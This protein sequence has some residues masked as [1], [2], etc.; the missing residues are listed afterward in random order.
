MSNPQTTA[1]KPSPA[2]RVLLAEDDAAMRTLL[3]CRLRR[4]GFEVVE[5]GNGVEALERLACASRDAPTTFDVVVSD[6]R[7]PGYDGFN[8]VASLR[9]TA[10]DLP[11]ILITAFGT[12]T[13][14]VTAARLGAYAILDKPFDLDDLMSLVT[15]AARARARWALPAQGTGGP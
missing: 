1:T 6:I 10:A 11:V 7:M 3:A 13:T 4:A 12:M 9:Q 2:G 8:I 15:A 14:H 5:A